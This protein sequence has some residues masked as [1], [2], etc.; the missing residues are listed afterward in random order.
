MKALV[1]IACL[2]VPAG[3]SAQALSPH[4]PDVLRGIV[5]ATA[6]LDY[7]AAETDLNGDGE[8]EIV[9]HLCGDGCRT[10]VLTGREADYAVMM[11]APGTRLP[12][13][14]GPASSHGWRDLGVGRPAEAM[15]LMRFD[16]RAYRAA[17]SPS[18]QPETVL[19]GE[20]AVARPLPRRD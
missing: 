6:E 20:D 15:A 4:V 11:D 3:A 5:G 16:G 17:A 18:T 7:V 14:V 19:I 8:P 2:A 10:L 1:L 13:R 12:I 9:A